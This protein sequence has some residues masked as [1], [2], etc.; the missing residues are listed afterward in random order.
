MNKTATTRIISLKSQISKMSTTSDSFRA[1][2]IDSN[3]K[4]K[5][6][7]TTIKNIQLGEIPGTMDTI[8][9]VEY[10]SINYKDGLAI[11]GKGK[12]VRTFPH[13]PGIDCAGIILDPGSSKFKS[14]DKVILTGFGFGERVWGGLSQRARVDAKWLVKL[15]EKLSAKQAMAIGT[16]GFTAEQCV[17]ALEEHGLKPGANIVVSGAAG[18]VGSV[19]V[20]ILAK[21]G[22]KVTAITGRPDSQ[23]EFLKS[24]GA[25]TIL[26]RSEIEAVGKSLDKEVFDG[27]I[28]TVGGQ[29]LTNILSKTRYLGSVA[30]CGLAASNAI[31]NASVFPFI[32]RGVNLL[33]IDSVMCP[34]E[35]REYVWKK[36]AEDL[37]L[38]VLD[39]LTHVVPLSQAVEKAEDIVK[40]KVAGRTVVDMSK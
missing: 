38:G 20:S 18:G 5:T 4:G 33:G 28:D 21:K 29:I 40:G 3:D 23:G 9:S 35:R 25:T 32:L 1:L 16:A 7:T 36:I 15:P 22:F 13:V 37:D 14:G 30:S 26:P 11:T 6:Q 19:A 10:S 34:M 31:P 8:L 17:L 39:K 2:V 24:L 12:I 27:G